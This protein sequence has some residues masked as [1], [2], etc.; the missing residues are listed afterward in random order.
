MYYEEVLFNVGK[1]KEFNPDILWI[2]T[3][4]RN[5]KKFPDM[6]FSPSQINTLIESEFEHYKSIWEYAKKI[7]H[8]W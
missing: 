5:I 3:T 7:F 4:W 8:V 6:D 2:H 1:L